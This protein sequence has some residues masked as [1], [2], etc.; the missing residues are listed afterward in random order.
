MDNVGQYASVNGRIVPVEEATVHILSPA[1][2]YASALFEGCRGYWNSDREALLLFRLDCHLKRLFQGMKI[3]RFESDV[4][5][6]TLRG[7]AMDLIRANG[8]R[9]TMY[10]RINAYIDG[11]G[12]Q[13]SRGPVSFAITT[14]P[15]QRS[16]AFEKGMRLGVSAW[17][18]VADAAMPPR[19]KSIA[20]YHNGRLAILD[21][22]AAG[23]DYPLFLTQSGKVSETAGSCF[24]IVRDGVIITPDVASDILESIT[25]DSAIW[26]AREKLGFQVLERP[27]DR[28]EVYIAEEAFLTGTHHEIRPVTALDSV[29]IGSGVAGPMTRR[30]QQAY[31]DLAEGRDDS[32]PDWKIEL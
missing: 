1:M 25:R 27:V 6:K 20:N 18:R 31:I 21:A 2:K 22:D 10:F 23:Y 24:F 14:T 26:L 5:P 15:L 29:A 11:T 12:N 13:G 7:W 17:L 30:L 19:V 4:T 8:H 9:E 16:E 32:R 28:S 3:L